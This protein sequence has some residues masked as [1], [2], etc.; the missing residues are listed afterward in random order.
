MIALSGLWRLVIILT[1][2]RIGSVVF[3]K[4][5]YHRAFKD[6]ETC[7]V[8]RRPALAVASM[9][10]VKLIMDFMMAINWELAA[11]IGDEVGGCRVN[12]H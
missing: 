7:V 3:P 4:L 12:A 8:S 2:S 5:L 9:W 1:R 6:V 10:E 11:L